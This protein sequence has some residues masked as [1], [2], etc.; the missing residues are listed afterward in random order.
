LLS[1]RS[2]E[3]FRHIDCDTVDVDAAGSPRCS[4]GMDIGES[5][6][7]GRADEVGETKTS[8]LGRS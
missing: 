5:F 1:A 4:E 6:I 7:G 3:Y 2:L 8:K